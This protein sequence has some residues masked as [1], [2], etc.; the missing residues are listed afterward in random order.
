MLKQ[1]PAMHVVLKRVR[2]VN[3][4]AETRYECVNNNVSLAFVSP[5]ILAFSV[6]LV[7]VLHHS[8]HRLTYI[9]FP[10][11]PTTS[12]SSSPPASR[13]LAQRAV[14]HHAV[15]VVLKRA[16]IAGKTQLKRHI[17]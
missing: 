7:A 14:A 17:L 15:H 6:V 9:L 13:V 16:R 10:L 8:S 5:R 2:L 4:S 12:S 1:L 3:K 11:L